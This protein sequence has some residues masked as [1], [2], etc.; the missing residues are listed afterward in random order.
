MT[1]LEVEKELLYKGAEICVPLYN[2]NVITGRVVKYINHKN[3]YDV[4][5]VST[6]HIVS[7]VR[8]DKDYLC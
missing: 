3:F 7:H 1:E 2:G 6:N 4:T 5:Y 8:I